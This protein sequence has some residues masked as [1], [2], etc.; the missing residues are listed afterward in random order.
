M[1]HRCVKNGGDDCQ[2]VVESA[3][4]N[5]EMQRF[6]INNL[7]GYAGYTYHSVDGDTD[8]AAEEELDVNFVES[9]QLQCEALVP[10]NAHA[11]SV[12]DAKS[13]SS[14]SDEEV[15]E[16]YTTPS[17]FSNYKPSA[18]TLMMLFGR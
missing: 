1:C 5:A 15:D 13:I 9:S 16:S 17:G 8:H 12:L 10:D 7:P 2:R 3:K 14:M 18:A 4:R 11:Q 6:S